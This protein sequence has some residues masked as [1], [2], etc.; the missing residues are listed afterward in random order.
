MKK[1]ISVKQN[2]NK[3]PSSVK[4]GLGKKGVQSTRKP[5]LNHIK[6]AVNKPKNK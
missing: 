1:Q 3:S 5:S 6:N 4:T 2:N